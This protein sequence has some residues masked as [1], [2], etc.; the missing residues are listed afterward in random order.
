MQWNEGQA[1]ADRRPWWGVG[2]DLIPAATSIASLVP[3]GQTAVHQAPEPVQ[4]EIWLALAAW[5]IS[6][7]STRQPFA[8]VARALLDKYPTLN[9]TVDELRKITERYVSRALAVHLMPDMVFR[10]LVE[11]NQDI[12]LLLTKRAKLAKLGDLLDEAYLPTSA[13]KPRDIAALQR[14]YTQLADSIE[15]TQQALGISPVPVTKVEKNET[16][17]VF[18]VNRALEKAGLASA[19]RDAMDASFRE[20]TAGGS[21]PA[22]TSSP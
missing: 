16:K 13:M 9:L 18:D 6:A 19:P 12:S 14:A 11:A 5:V 2:K 1:E 4:Q 7:P 22:S 8:E 21:E 15:E 10:G 20:S 3:A 17:R